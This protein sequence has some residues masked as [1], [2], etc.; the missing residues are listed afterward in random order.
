MSNQLQDQAQKVQAL[1]QKKCDVIETALK[2]GGGASNIKLDEIL[3]AT[4]SPL[5]TAAS[6]PSPAP[7]PMALPPPGKQV[8]NIIQVHSLHRSP[9][10]SRYACRSFIKMKS[11]PKPS[12]AL[13][14][15]NW[16][17]LPEV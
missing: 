7:A 13:K 15:L 6:P 11:I 12:N 14:P 4:T 2:E 9:S 1:L 16:T 5:P 3:E 10:S 17:K 8:N